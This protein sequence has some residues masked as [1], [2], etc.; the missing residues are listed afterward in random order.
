M[1]GQKQTNVK[2]SKQTKQEVPSNRGGRK[3]DPD[4]NNGWEW[5]NEMFNEALKPQHRATW[6]T[7]LGAGIGWYL[8]S[9]LT[10]VRRPLSWQE[11]RTN[12]LEKG[13]V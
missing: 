4:K 12:F 5:F 3:P 10:D 7:L 11:F 2:P 8:F 9:R 13:E 6:M 1:G